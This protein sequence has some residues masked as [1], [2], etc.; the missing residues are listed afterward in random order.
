MKN[1]YD[2]NYPR[3]SRVICVVKSNKEIVGKVLI[4]DE[5]SYVFLSELISKA[6][7]CELDYEIS[8]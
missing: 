7:D 2:T 4:E 8:Q 3:D 5:D 6:G 1:W